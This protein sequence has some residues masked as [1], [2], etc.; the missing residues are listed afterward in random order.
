M[1]DPG[2]WSPTVKLT[3][4]L[5]PAFMALFGL[6]ITWFVAATKWFVV[7]CEALGNSPGMIE[8]RRRWGTLTL[9]SRTLVVS[10]VSAGLV[11]PRWAI[12]QGLLAEEDFN[13]V[14][15]Y[16]KF[17]L[18][19]SFWSSSVGVILLAVAYHLVVD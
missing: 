18:L 19:L 11:W 10:G 17:A 5:L 16:L 12:C 3:V 1:I 4:L 6:G 15:A 2:N 13:A 7:L 8:E 14:P 9:K